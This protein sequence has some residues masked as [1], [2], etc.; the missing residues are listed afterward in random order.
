[1]EGTANNKLKYQIRKKED[2]SNKILQHFKNLVNILVIKFGITDKIDQGDKNQ[3]ISHL[4]NV[5]PQRDQQKIYNQNFY[6]TIA[7]HK[8]LYILY[9][10]NKHVSF[11]DPRV[12]RILN[13]NRDLFYDSYRQNQ[14]KKNFIQ[15]LQNKL[16]QLNSKFNKSYYLTIIRKLCQ[17][18]SNPQDAPYK[19]R[20]IIKQIRQNSYG[21]GKKI[22]KN[23]I[24]RVF[25]ILKKNFKQWKKQYQMIQKK[26]LA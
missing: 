10:K 18:L 25:Y 11:T 19:R 2:I 13:R 7:Y 26:Q 8:L 5:Y 3:I 9:R 15:F 21:N 17:F 16:L 4:A 24:Y 23:Y 1:M 6:F 20:D 12:Q 14:Q 22:P